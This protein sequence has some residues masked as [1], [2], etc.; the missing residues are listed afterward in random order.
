MQ[1]ASW[2]I[3][4]ALVAGV[5]AFY[6][7]FVEDVGARWFLVALYSVLVVAIVSLDLYTR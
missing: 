6:V 1:I 4:F 7:P 5:Y 2:L 3:F